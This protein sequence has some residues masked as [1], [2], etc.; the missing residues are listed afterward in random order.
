MMSRRRQQQ[1]LV[2][3]GETAD[4]ALDRMI[5]EHGS[6]RRARSENL[7]ERRDL[8]RMTAGGEPAVRDTEVW[9]LPPGLHHG[10]EHG[11]GGA[12]A[13]GRGPPLPPGGT[14]VVNILEKDRPGA[15]V[16]GKVRDIKE[17]RFTA[18]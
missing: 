2:R 18:R 1:D 7:E 5:R 11:A 3:D 13:E 8:R 12:G 6:S 17:S 16:M 14:E 9:T 15:V 10:D 4:Q